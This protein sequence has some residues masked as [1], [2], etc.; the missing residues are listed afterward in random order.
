MSELNIKKQKLIEFINSITEEDFN[1]ISLKQRIKGISKYGK[2]V[3]DC[4]TKDY[5]WQTMA[6][7]E[8]VDCS[9]YLD[10]LEKHKKNE[11]N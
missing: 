10:M 5:N 3:E 11:S 6:L 1:K 8:I 7:E 4:Y 2:Y 9:G